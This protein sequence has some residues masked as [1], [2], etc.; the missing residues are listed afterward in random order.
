[1]ST[2]KKFSAASAK[3]LG[4]CAQSLQL[5]CNEVLQELDI[6][7]ICGTRGE[8]EQQEAFKTGKSKLQFPNS[9]HNSLPSQAVDIAPYPVDWNDIKGFE[10]MLTVVERC[11]EKLNIDIR[12]GRDFKFRDYPHVELK[13]K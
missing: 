11:A 4:T 1:M 10:N 7:V 12:L 8:A 9:K 3:K 6:T 13:S 5:L 2:M